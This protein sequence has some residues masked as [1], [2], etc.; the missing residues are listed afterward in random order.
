MF[1]IDYPPTQYEGF[2]NKTP[3][4]TRNV[5]IKYRQETLAMELWLKVYVETVKLDKTYNAAGYANDAVR[6]FEHK[7]KSPIA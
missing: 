6:E 1:N 7:F 2:S 4:E 5:Y 3:K